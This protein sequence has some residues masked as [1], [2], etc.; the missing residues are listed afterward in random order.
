LAKEV[1]SKKNVTKKRRTISPFRNVDE[2]EKEIVRFM[3]LNKASFS[4]HAKRLSDYFEM[5]C[6]NY[7]VKFYKAK[8]Y[9]IEIENL[10]DGK[11]RYKCST[12]G[13]QENFSNFKVSKKVG[14]QLFEYAIYHNIAIQSFHGQDI[15]TTS[16]ISIVR[17]GK[18]NTDPDHYGGKKKLSF[19]ANGD[20]IS[21]CEVKQFPPFPELMFSFIG[22]VNELIHGIM[23]QQQATYRPVHL[24][25]SLMISGKPNAHALRIKTSLEK[26]YCVNIIYDLF[27]ASSHPFS[28][29]MIGQL[30][31]IKKQEDVFEM[32]L[33]F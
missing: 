22:I 5:C 29:H 33:A 18:I 2:L 17:Y 30:K 8:G 13:N 1:T 15:Y 27:A 10:Q 32:D 6:F 4:N 16:D 14:E 20:L 9:G 11:Y 7:V 3:N 23:V 28:T 25:P 19:I 24:A 21:F 12:Q 26:R 31:T